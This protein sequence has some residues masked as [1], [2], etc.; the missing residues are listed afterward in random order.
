MHVVRRL[1][2][3]LTDIPSELPDDPGAELPPNIYRVGLW[4]EI[5]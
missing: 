1:I 2:E 3:T 4:R 5:K